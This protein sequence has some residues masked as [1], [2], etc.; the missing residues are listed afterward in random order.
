MRT[1]STLIEFIVFPTFLVSLACSQTWSGVEYLGHQ[2]LYASIGYN[3]CW[4]YTGPDGREYA[5]LGV[6]SGAS[7]VDITD[8]PTL[9][10]IAFIPNPSG[11]SDAMDIKTYRQYAYVAND[12]AGGINIIDLSA[13]PASAHLATTYT[14]ITHTHNIYIDTASALLYAQHDGSKAVIVLSLANPLQPVPIDSFGVQCHDIFVRDNR[15]YVSEGAYG[16][17]AIYDVSVFPQ[18]VFLGRVP[19]PI[20]GG[21]AHN[22]W[23]TEDGNYLMTTYETHGRKTKLWNISNPDSIYSLG[24]YLGPTG[25]AHNVHIKGNYA[26]IS[27]YLD[28][29][30]I[31][32]IADTI[33]LSEVAF[34]DSYPSTGSGYHGAWGTFPFFASG[35]V[36]ISDIETGLYV[37]RYPPSITSVRE[38]EMLKDFVLHQ[39]HPNPFNPETAIGYQLSGAG[40]VRLSVFDVLGRER[41]VL[42]DREE[43][44][45]SH[46][47]RWDASAMPSGIYFY[48]LVAGGR[49]ETKRMVL[50]R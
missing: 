31:V 38:K 36:V 15:A 28:G 21:F 37:V 44:A 50:I 19:L 6:R 24:E 3:D 32:N 20:D 7:I 45:G 48:R 11:N 27:H 1:M 25:L 30:R 22:A 43:G 5:L 41:A 4:G 40:E 17:F 34:F 49:S 13:L 29:L 47:V 35:K 16:T 23:L 14:G 18:P 8:A 46:D 42:V 33:D 9:K 39:N 12:D 2:N 26:Y 10:E